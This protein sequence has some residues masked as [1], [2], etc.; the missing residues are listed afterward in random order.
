MQQHER[1][2]GRRHLSARPS[3][4]PRLRLAPATA[5]T[6]ALTGTLLSSTAGPATAADG[7]HSPLADINGDGID[8]ATLSA[9]GAYVSGEKDAGQQLL[10]LSGAKTAVSSAKRSAIGRNTTGNPGTAETG[11]VSGTD[12]AYADFDGDGC[13]DLA[14]SSPLEDVGS[15]KDGGAVPVLWASAQGITVSR[16][17]SPGVSDVRGIPGVTGISTTGY[18]HLGADFAG[19]APGTD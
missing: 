14:V 16:T 12:G 13:D 7:T 6:T 4:R 11:D 5:A 15:D 9:S 1:P 10:T 19:R 18:P 2:S 8:D 17:V 3:R